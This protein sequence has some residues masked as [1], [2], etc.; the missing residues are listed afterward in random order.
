F[1]QSVIIFTSNIGS[2]RLSLAGTEAGELPTYEAVRDHYQAA[3]RDHFSRPPTQGGLGRPELL[4]RFGDNVLVFDLL[5]PEYVAG[6]SRKFLAILTATAQEKRGL[7]LAFTD[8][9]VV[10]RVRRQ[11]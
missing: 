9:G 3:V 2:D 5:R 7:K 10:D 4:N 6:I 1:S 11:M 8:G